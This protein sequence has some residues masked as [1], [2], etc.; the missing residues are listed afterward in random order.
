[1]IASV[2]C[3]YI[4]TEEYVYEGQLSLVMKGSKRIGE[5]TKSNS[6]GK[7]RVYLNGNWTFVCNKSFGYDE[8]ECSCKQLGYTGHSTYF[9]LPNVYG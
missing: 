7:L 1:M 3:I 5:R 8:A 4:D 6:Q 9:T 2:P